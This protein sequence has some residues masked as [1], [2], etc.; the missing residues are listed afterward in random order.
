MVAM[1]ENEPSYRDNAES[2]VQHAEYLTMRACPQQDPDWHDVNRILS[3]AGDA[4]G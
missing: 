1:F 4:T 3:F 2:R